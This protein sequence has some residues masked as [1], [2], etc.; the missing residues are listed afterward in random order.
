MLESD[1]FDKLDAI[2]QAC[3][4]SSRPFGGVQLILC[5]GE[6]SLC[7]VVYQPTHHMPRAT[8][9]NPSLSISCTVARAVDFFQLPPVSKGREAGFCF[10]ARAWGHAVSRC[11]VLRQVFRQT[12]QEFVQILNELRTA[13][14]S[15]SSKAR[16]ASAAQH[17]LVDP[18]P[19]RLCTRNE[20]AD[21]LNRERLRGLPGT[22]AT[23]DAVDTGEQY[24]KDQLNKNSSAPARLELKVGAKVILLKNIAIDGG[25]VN[26]SRGTVVGFSQVSADAEENS[27]SKTKGSASASGEGE[28]S[29]CPVVEFLDAATGSKTARVVTNE[30]FTIEQQV[31]GINIYFSNPCA[32]SLQRCCSQKVSSKNDFLMLLFC[33]VGG[34][35]GDADSVS[36][37]ACVGYLDPQVSG[38]DYRLPRG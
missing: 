6:P 19:T 34:H 21:A 13:T 31:R 10:E 7:S 3:K 15:P 27:K 30:E 35:Q 5:G 9:R 8:L 32:H 23:F 2:G 4:K 37:Q 1:L 14:L 25:L 11:V 16:L 20:T 17:K 28:Q 36:S 24:F 12:N 22:V 18:E 29:L 26:G 38:H 33:C